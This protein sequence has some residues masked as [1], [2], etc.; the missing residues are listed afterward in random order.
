M[1][2]VNIKPTGL[3]INQ[4]SFSYA[5]ELS[6]ML[7]AFGPATYRQTQ[8]LNEGRAWRK[9]IIFDDYGVYLLYDEEIRRVLDI[10]F[11]LQT[12][13]GETSP[14]KVFSGLLFVNGVRLTG[15]TKEQALPVTGEFQF[16]KQGGWEARSDTV[17]VHIRTSTKRVRAVAITFLKRE[18]FGCEEKNPKV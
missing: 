12:S 4:R 16:A 9:F 15:A 8:I 14:A 10:H 1:V 3:I 2:N 11:C 18:R 5:P 6:A 7:H 17:S 13:K